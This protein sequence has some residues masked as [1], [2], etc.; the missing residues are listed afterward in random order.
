MLRASSGKHAR[1]VGVCRAGGDSI[2]GESGESADLF[3]L[4][5][6]YR[7]IDVSTSGKIVFKTSLYMEIERP[8]PSKTAFTYYC[9]GAA[10]S[11]SRPKSS[12]PGIRQPDLP[13]YW[14]IRAQQ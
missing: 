7:E 9:W 10:S 3:F 14:A 11:K 6:L 8:D 1:L 2:S 5:S 4:R 13:R 12:D